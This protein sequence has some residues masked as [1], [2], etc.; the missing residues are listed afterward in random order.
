VAL[1]AA[2]AVATEEQALAALMAVVAVR[3]ETPARP[4]AHS[5]SRRR[6]EYANE[7]ENEEDGSADDQR[8]SLSGAPAP[9]HVDEPANC[10]LLVFR[11]EHN[12]GARP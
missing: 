1:A 8:F 5:M 10:G 4:T 3:R 7:H 11:Q 6:G 2:E 9:Q 12:L